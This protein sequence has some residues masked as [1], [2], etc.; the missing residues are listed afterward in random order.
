MCNLLITFETLVAIWTHMSSSHHVGDT[1]VC[2][3]QIIIYVTMVK[4]SRRCARC[5]N[6]Q[7]CEECTVFVV[8]RIAQ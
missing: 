4:V 7:H 1:C 2:Y 6:I 3:V 8:Y 5:E